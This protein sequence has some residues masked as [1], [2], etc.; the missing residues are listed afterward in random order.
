MGGEDA[1]RTLVDSIDEL[2]ANYRTESAAADALIRVS[3]AWAMVTALD[4]AVSCRAVGYGLV[5]DQAAPH[6][7]GP[8]HDR[9]SFRPEV[10]SREVGAAG[11]TRLVP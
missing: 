2:A 11:T 9:G 6:G 7:E 4:P 10:A 8:R 1:I 3:A 5:D